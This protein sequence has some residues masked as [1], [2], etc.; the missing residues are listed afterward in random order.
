M[1]EPVITLQ[2]EELTRSFGDGSTR[3]TA[4]DAVS[5]DIHA[6]EVSL[7]M[8]PSGSGKST[9]LA[10]LSG[11]LQPDSGRVMTLGHDL[12]SLSEQQREAFRLRY[13][14]FIFQGYN[15]FAALTA[16]QQLEMIA[17]WGEGASAR[18]ARRRA[19]EIL[20]L[21]GLARRAHLR[22]LELSGGEKQRVAIG[23]ALIKNPR[24]MFADEPTSALDWAHGEQVIEL[25][26]NA[27]H[28]RGTSVL[29][30][31]HDARIIPFADRVF[32]LEDGRLQD[33][34][35]S[36]TPGFPNGRYQPRT[37]TH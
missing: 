21:L 11:L 24:M 4:L 14:G 3:T 25:L 18:E 27:A 1:E 26:R 9:L 17:R 22:P 2:G 33:H 13:C 20:S 23:R 7:L 16:R 30:V 15:L 8:G 36:G 10:V 28:D 6:G 34:P 19:D 37:M 29:I 35:D 12:W 32:Y 31:A 5:L